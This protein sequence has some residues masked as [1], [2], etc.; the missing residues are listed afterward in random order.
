M[1][2]VYENAIRGMINDFEWFVDI[3][4]M[5]KD[6]LRELKDELLIYHDPAFMESV[7]SSPLQ[8]AR[9]PDS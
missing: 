8:L 2:G 5:R 6:E 9:L 4:A 7:T 3:L 1:G